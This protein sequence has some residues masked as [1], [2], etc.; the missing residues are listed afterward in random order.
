VTVA[1]AEQIVGAMKDKGIEYDYLLVDDEG[2]GFVKPGNRL[3]FYEMA[4]AFL[5]KHL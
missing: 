3:R 4:E 5:A 2:H 1:E